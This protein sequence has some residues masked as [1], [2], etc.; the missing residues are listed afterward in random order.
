M[1][2]LRKS[3]MIDLFTSDIGMPTRSLISP[4]FGFDTWWKDFRCLPKRKVGKPWCKAFWI[5]NKLAQQA[6]H[7]MLYTLWRLEEEPNLQYFPGP[8][9]FL[10]AGGWDDWKPFAK[11]K[12]K[13]WLQEYAEH[14]KRAVPMPAN[15]RKQR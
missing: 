15:L 3:S 11:P 10:N 4:D 12:P 5:R 2:S 7:I 8:K 9:P 6:T 14:E 1:S 13:D